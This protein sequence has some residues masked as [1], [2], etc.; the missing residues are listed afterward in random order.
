MQSFTQHT[1][2][3]AVLNRG[4]IDTDQIIPKDF[5]KSI[6]KTGYGE[7]LFQDWRYL[8]NGKPNPRFELNGPRYEG[9]SMLVAG[10]NFGC[11]SSREHA[12][13]A[14]LQAGFR[15]VIAPRKETDQAST[16][17]FADI[18]KSNSAKNGLLLIEL[19][20]E[21]T[22][23]LMDTLEAH[24]D[25]Q[26]TVDLPAQ[27][28]ILHFG[29]SSLSDGEKEFSFIIDPDLKKHFLEGCDEIARTLKYE[30]EIALFE[31]NHPA[32]LNG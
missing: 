7:H 28:I 3:I 30:K 29:E 1:G 32:I 13:W 8:D 16:P 20:E 5:L 22:M 24:E 9:A 21:S 2:K 25:L 18:F 23:E 19:D 14:I 11:G 4:N 31:K 27:K 10:N 12:V 26:A 17:A 15:V 6:K